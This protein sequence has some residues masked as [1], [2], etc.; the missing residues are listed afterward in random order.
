MK[1]WTPTRVAARPGFTLVELLVVIALVAA[2]AGML[3]PALA[4]AR[5]AAGTARCVSNLRQYAVAAQLYWDDHSGR[6]FPERSVYTNGGWTY[7]FG[8]L[9]DGAEGAREFDPRSG[10][11]WSYMGSRGVALCPGLDRSGAA[12]KSK[13]RGA[14]SG[15]AYNQLLG[16][17]NA[18]PEDVGRLAAPGETAVFADGAQANDFQPPASPEHPM[19][20]EFYY[21][22]TNRLEAT[23]HFRHDDRAQA[24]WADGHVAGE[25]PEP[26][27]EDRRVPGQLLGRLPAGHVAPRR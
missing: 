20:E 3:L 15:Y 11:L 7:W 4:R 16:P 2:L 10:A 9:Q 17:R 12:F 22:G 5:R 18:A 21:F 13:A 24:A 8:W 23:V 1:S 25:R 26:G 14:A 19:L 6:T 27:S